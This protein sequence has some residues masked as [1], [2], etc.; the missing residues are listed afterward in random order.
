[1][2]IKMATQMATFRSG[3]TRA[4][5]QFREEVF[6][7]GKVDWQYLQVCAWSGQTPPH[8]GQDLEYSLSDMSEN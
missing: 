7:P 3:P 4:A 6:T 8:S 2:I 1:V 5:R